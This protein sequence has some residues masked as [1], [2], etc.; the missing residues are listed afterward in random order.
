MRLELFEF[1]RH[2]GEIPAKANG[3]AVF[4][5]V[6]RHQLCDIGVVFDHQDFVFHRLPRSSARD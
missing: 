6:E 4:F 2:V 5:Q 1:T 3:K